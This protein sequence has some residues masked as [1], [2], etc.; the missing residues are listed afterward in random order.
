M[1]ELRG[2]PSID[3]TGY[4][5]CMAPELLTDEAVV[6]ALSGLD[7]Q[8]E[9]DELV[10]TE[11][12]KD[13]AAALAFVNEVGALAEGRNHHPDISISWNKVTLRLSTHSAGGLTHLDVDLAKAVDAL[14]A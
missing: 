13:F 7:W 9:G 6:D 5:Y 3:S 8:R 2:K 1:P 11:I 14:R 10:K 12:L 4:K